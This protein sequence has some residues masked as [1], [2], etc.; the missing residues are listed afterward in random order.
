MLTVNI[1]IDKLFERIDLL[2]ED[3]NKK[4]I[5]DTKVYKI[6]I[7]LIAILSLALHFL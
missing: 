2:Q 1:R 6:A 7:G 5:F 4:T 3:I